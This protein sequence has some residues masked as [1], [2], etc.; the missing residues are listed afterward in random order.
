MVVGSKLN[1]PSALLSFVAILN[2][3]ALVSSK[4]IKS[5]CTVLEY[6]FGTPLSLINLV[7]SSIS[8]INKLTDVSSNIDVSTSN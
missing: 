1:V 5:A 6:Q 3:S 8:K 2:I 7:S 4:L